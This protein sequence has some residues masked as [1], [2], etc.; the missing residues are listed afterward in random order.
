MHFIEPGSVIADRFAIQE[1]IGEGRMSFVYSALDRAM[2][3]ARVA[4]KILNTAQPNAIR[5][6]VFKRETEALRRLSHPN[7]V[8][9]RD[10]GYLDHEDT[11][12]L[13]L[14]YLPYSLDGYLKGSSPRAQI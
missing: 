6:E 13:A 12:Y 5:R 2:S 7:I 14:D 9:M 1:R 11:F 8:G 10:S 4:V 3:N